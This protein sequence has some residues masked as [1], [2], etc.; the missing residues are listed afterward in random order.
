MKAVIPYPSAS[1]CGADVVEGCIASV[2]ERF[3]DVDAFVV[4]VGSG[5]SELAVRRVADSAREASGRPVGVLRARER[6]VNGVSAIR[7][8]LKA[9]IDALPDEASVLFVPPWW[10]ASCEPGLSVSGITGG[11]ELADDVV[12]VMLAGWLWGGCGGRV[13]YFPRP[14]PHEGFLAVQ[15]SHY[16]DRWVFSVDAPQAVNAALFR[17]GGIMS[18]SGLSGVDK[19]VQ[20]NYWGR[21]D[22]N[23]V[24]VPG[25]QV[26]PFTDVLCVSPDYRA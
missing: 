3:S 25:N 13:N 12:S 26:Q 16:T 24:L 20:S 6:A 8:C 10:H 23:M 2:A 17:D 11:V 19:F 9:C 4:A 18:D 5:R 14:C 15:S 21:D 1:M 7:L 22:A